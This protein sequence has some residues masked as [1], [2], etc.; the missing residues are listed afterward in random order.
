MLEERKAVRA[1][2]LTP[3]EDILLMR[4][5]KPGGAKPFW[6]TPGGGLEPGEGAEDCLRRE[7]REELGLLEFETGP[8][9]WLRHHTCDWGSR[10]IAQSEE[11]Y[12]VRTGHFEPR[13]SDPVEASVV[14]VFRWWPAA[15]LASC[16][17]ELTPAALAKI[18]GHFLE[19]G[20]V[21][22][23]LEVERLVD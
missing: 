2:L 8:L 1:V 12:I 9:V 7:L 16:G 19:T 21:I 6:V 13:M 18:V 22:H 3:E 14:D 4:I 11:Y 5:R 15:A 23:P 20:S 10:R 17:E